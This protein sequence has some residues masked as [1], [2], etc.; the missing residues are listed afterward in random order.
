MKLLNQLPKN[1]EENRND[2]NSCNS[3]LSGYNKFG[4]I[5]IRE[6]YEAARE[7]KLIKQLYWRDF[8]YHVMLNNGYSA[9]QKKYEDIKWDGEYDHLNAWKDGKTGTPIV[10]AAM[11]CLARTGMMHNRLRMIT[12]SY[13]VKDLLIDWKEG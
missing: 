8:Y 2:I 4:A 11:R 10:D 3:N 5:S 13:L 1:Y 12:A 9:T 7:E 6:F